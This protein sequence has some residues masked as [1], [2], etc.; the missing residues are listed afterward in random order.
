MHPALKTS[1]GTKIQ[2]HEFLSST[3]DWCQWSASRSCCFNSVK[4]NKCSRWIG[5][6]MGPRSVW[7]LWKR[8]K[9]IAAK[10]TR[11]LVPWGMCS[12]QLRCCTDSCILDA[13]EFRLNPLVSSISTAGIFIKYVSIEKKLSK[14]SDVCRKSHTMQPTRFVIYAVKCSIVCNKVGRLYVFSKRKIS[15]ALFTCSLC[16]DTFS[17]SRLDDVDL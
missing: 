3:P 1:T 4:E 2:H 9:S 11:T 14:D 6:L 17:N 16:H 13:W 5:G 12:R 8:W 7:A 15:Q 10:R